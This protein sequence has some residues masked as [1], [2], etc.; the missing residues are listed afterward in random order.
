MIAAKWVKKFQACDP[1]DYKQNL[2]LFVMC[3]TKQI[4]VDPFNVAPIDPASAQWPKFERE[5]TLHDINSAVVCEIYKDSLTP[6]YKIEV[7]NTLR[8][9]VCYQNIP[10][11]GA[12]F[13]YAFSLHETID[14][15]SKFNKLNIPKNQI[16]SLRHEDVSQPI[17]TRRRVGTPGGHG[18]KNNKK[19]LRPAWEGPIPDE[20]ESEA[21]VLQPMMSIPLSISKPIPVALKKRMEAS[22]AKSSELKKL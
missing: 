1:K 12:H 6:P 21:S 22:L 13:Y 4:L 5:Y 18:T 14:K 17:A 16:E 8:E 10:F 2:S 11:F 15:W 20:F 9:Y 3:L 19:V 7:S